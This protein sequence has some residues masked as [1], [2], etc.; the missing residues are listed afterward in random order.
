[1]EDMALTATDYSPDDLA[2]ILAG[3][4][5]VLDATWELSWLDKSRAELVAFL[6]HALRQ[7]PRLVTAPFIANVTSFW[8]LTVADAE[9]AVLDLLAMHGE[10]AGGSIVEDLGTLAVIFSA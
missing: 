3:T 5:K 7:D 1:M 4:R 8:T 2:D 9:A 10:T 6:V